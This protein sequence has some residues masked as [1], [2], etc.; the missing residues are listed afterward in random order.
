MSRASTIRYAFAGPT[1]ELTEEFIAD[2]SLIGKAKWSNGDGG[3]NLG[4]TLAFA[5][6]ASVTFP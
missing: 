5:D 4:E 2:T 6:Q 1:L 3:A